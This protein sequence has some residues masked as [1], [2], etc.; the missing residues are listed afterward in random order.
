MKYLLMAS[1]FV[2]SAKAM[3][4]TTCASSD[5]AFKLFITESKLVQL[6]VLDKSVSPAPLSY[7]CEKS[8]MTD[9]QEQLAAYAC[10][11]GGFGEEKP[12][13]VYVNESQGLAN[14]QDLSDESKDKSDLNC[15]ISR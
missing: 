2:L 10:L 12:V 1:M 6:L 4:Y 14:F 7:V 11:G 15:E 8:S 9:N 5:E 13:A 3:A